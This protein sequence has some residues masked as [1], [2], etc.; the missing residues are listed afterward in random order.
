MTP[1]TLSALESGYHFQ[2][3]RAAKLRLGLQAIFDFTQGQA[4]GSREY[5]IHMLAHDLLSATKE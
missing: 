4:I 2:R 5:Y 1:E 3:A